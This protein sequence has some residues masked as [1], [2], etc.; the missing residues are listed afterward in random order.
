MLALPTLRPATTPD[1][2]ALARLINDAFR[3]E[4]FFSDEDRT[5][6]NGVR[7]YMK[8]G[9]F[10]IAEDAGTLVGCVYLEPRAKRFYLG[11]LSVEPSRQRAGLGSFLM[12]VA[13]DHCKAEGAHGIDLHIVNVR[14][15]LPAYY[16][17]FGYTETGTA[18]FPAHVKTKIPCH[19][20]IM[21]K[22]LI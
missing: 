9:T 10:L 15:E 18:P 6:P 21:S 4:R 7:D 5:N 3:S 8:K 13:E 19:F 11:L 14:T 1:A 17:R 12:R 20:V 16:H 2:E 22:E